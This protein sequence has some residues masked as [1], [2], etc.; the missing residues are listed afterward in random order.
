MEV[1]FLFIHKINW[2]LALIGPVISGVKAVTGSQQPGICIFQSKE[3]IL[4]A[5]G[6]PANK[7]DTAFNM[8][9]LVATG[10]VAKAK[11]KLII[12]G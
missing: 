6:F 8:A 1:L 12:S 2:P 7:L 9:F 10:Y 4:P 5:K 3:A 11:M